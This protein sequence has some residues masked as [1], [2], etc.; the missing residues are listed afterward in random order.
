MNLIP[1]LK[2]R[3]KFVGTLRVE[4]LIRVPEVCSNICDDPYHEPEIVSSIPHRRQIKVCRDESFQLASGKPEV[5]FCS[6]CGF[7]LDEW[8]IWRSASSALQCLQ[9]QP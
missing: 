7:E 1:A 3:A 9:S 5:T 2:R 8:W 4:D 6:E